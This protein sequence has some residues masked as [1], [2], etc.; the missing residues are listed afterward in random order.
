MRPH[1]R[2]LGHSRAIRFTADVHQTHN[3][4][5]IIRNGHSRLYGGCMTNAAQQL[6][7]IYTQY[8][9]LSW[10]AHQ[11]P[12]RTYPTRRPS[13]RVI[14][15]NAPTI[16]YRKVWTALEHRRDDNTPTDILLLLVL[17]SRSTRSYLVHRPKNKDMYFVC[18]RL[19][20]NN[21]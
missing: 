18:I 11:F 15:A 21:Q 14:L 6:H 12:C 2:P 4:P 9:L 10:P 7:N 5:Y 16:H 19:E 3:T 20:P 17:D 13:S 1:G 8:R